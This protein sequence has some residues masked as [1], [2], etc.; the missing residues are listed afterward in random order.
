MAPRDHRSPRRRPGQVRRYGWSTGRTAPHQSRNT[1]KIL[2]SIRNL[3]FREFAVRRK[4]VLVRAG[5]VRSA[6][7]QLA[8]KIEKN[9]QIVALSRQFAVSPLVSTLNRPL[10]TRHPRT[11]RAP[12]AA[13]GYRHLFALTAGDLSDGGAARP[14]DREL[15]TEDIDQGRKG[16]HGPVAGSGSFASDRWLSTGRSVPL[17]G[18][19]NR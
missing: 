8:P 4:K 10:S 3:C 6:C 1:W 19:L 13:L 15:A 9:W 14:E 12:P 17:S 2:K 7:C 18:P 5:R 11:S 16:E